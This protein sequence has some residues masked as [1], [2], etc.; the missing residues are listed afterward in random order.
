LLCLAIATGCGASQAAAI[1]TSDGVP[2]AEGSDCDATR[3]GGFI[4]IGGDSF[5]EVEHRDCILG[6]QALSGAGVIR[7]TM[8][9]KLIEKQRGVYDWA[10]T[11]WDGWMLSVA[12]HRLKVLPILFN[13]P[14]MYGR[15][16]ETGSFPPQVAPYAAF[17][18]A[19]VERYGSNGT[20]WQEHPEVPK[21]PI[22]DWQMWN[23]PNLMQYWRPKP[24]ARKYTRLL[25]AAYKAAKRADRRAQV[26]TAGMPDSFLGGAVRL[27]KFVTQMYAAGAARW[28]DVLGVNLYGTRAKQVF[29]SMAEMRLLMDAP[30]V[31][32]VLRKVFKAKPKK[33]RKTL[34][35]LT[36]RLPRKA[37]K[38]GVD[39]RGKLW[40]T[41]IG[42][43][44]A[45]PRHRFNIG[46]RAQAKQIRLLFKGLYK[47]RR[48]LKLRGVF[49][50]GWQDLPP[51]PAG[52]DDEWGYHT[53]LFDK[54]GNAKP[55]YEAFRSTAPRLR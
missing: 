52:S 8:D 10:G 29:A 38:K 11:G 18:R 16:A 7:I 23:E 17:V 43:G 30:K 49:Y 35:A 47:Q 28:F 51:Y 20:F 42:W 41:E 5:N 45:G 37:R 14:P 50:F 22:T 44:T 53:G 48:K 25:K 1:D 19:A 4:G 9:W 12:R 26:V 6:L 24:S 46:E 39:K 34:K 27:R 13:T 2:K 21:V 33:R 31:P 3:T 36:R 15:Q 40:L 32:S 54:N 55:G